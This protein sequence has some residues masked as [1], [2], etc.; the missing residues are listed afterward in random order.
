MA[1]K[2]SAKKFDLI[3]NEVVVSIGDVEVA[4][5]RT[6]SLNEFF[7]FVHDVVSYCFDDE[8]DAYR[9][10]AKDFAI[11]HNLVERYTDV[12]LPGNVDHEYAIFYQ[13]N[14]IQEILD[15]INPEQY[16]NL[17][18]A[19]E[20]MT[21]HRLAVKESAAEYSAQMIM[22]QMSDFISKTESVLGDIG[23]PEMAAA[24]SNLAKIGD[25]AEKDI[26]HAVL[27]HDN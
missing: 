27:E 20:E 17:L 10:E 23:G 24:I 22:R 21:A 1:K 16:N 11:K 3:D 18:L 14:L 6:I 12:K 19:I 25:V 26:L 4:V 2:I 9:P 7:N 5:K 8:E 15:K 13:T